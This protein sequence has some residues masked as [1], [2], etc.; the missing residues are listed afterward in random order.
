MA[1]LASQPLDANRR[2]GPVRGSER[3]VRV[4][5][6]FHHRQASPERSYLWCLK[7]GPPAGKSGLAPGRRGLRRTSSR[8]NA[9]QRSGAPDEVQL[10][11]LIEAAHRMAAMI[12]YDGEIYKRSVEP[13][14]MQSWGSHESAWRLSASADELR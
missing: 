12:E 8:A 5:L 9:S 14:L 6:R 2:H 7:T 10:R 11:R 1:H 3:R 4:A 13:R